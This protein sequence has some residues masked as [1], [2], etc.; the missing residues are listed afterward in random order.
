MYLFMVSLLSK[1]A[2][3]NWPNKTFSKFVDMYN[4][5]HTKGRILNTHPL[6]DKNPPPN[7]WIFGEGNSAE[8]NFVF[9][10]TVLVLAVKKLTSL[11]N[12]RL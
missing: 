3:V 4:C 12:L 2:F 8:K 5:T 9:L 11:T 1:N 10:F 6:V 7:F